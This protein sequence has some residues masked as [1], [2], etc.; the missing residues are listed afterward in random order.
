MTAILYMRTMLTVGAALIS[1]TKTKTHNLKLKTRLMSSRTTRTA[2]GIKTD[3]KV[4]TNPTKR[5]PMPET[6]AAWEKMT[7]TPTQHGT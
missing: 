6:K 1:T 7:T 4:K 5:D 2:I 3:F